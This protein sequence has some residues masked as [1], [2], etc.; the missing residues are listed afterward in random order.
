ML[1]SYSIWYQA[2]LWIFPLSLT[3][4]KFHICLSSLLSLLLSI[5]RGANCPLGG[6]LP[7]KLNTISLPLYEVDD[8]CINWREEVILQ[9]W[10]RRDGSW[11]G[12]WENG[13][14]RVWNIESWK[15]GIWSYRSMKY[16]NVHIWEC[17]SIGIHY[18][19]EWVWEYGNGNV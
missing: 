10:L 9:S 11:N 5:M 4:V 15:R 6:S 14:M 1:W 3:S 13:S 19:A 8:I 16:R 12:V 7:A 18:V 2:L 17:V